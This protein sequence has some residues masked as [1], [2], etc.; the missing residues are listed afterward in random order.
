V[1]ALPY[2]SCAVDVVGSQGRLQ[3]Q[4]IREI[5]Q[6][7]A[8]GDDLNTNS[9]VDHD[10]DVELVE[11]HS[12]EGTETYRDGDVPTERTVERMEA[13]PVVRFAFDVQKVL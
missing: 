1:L 4:H 11:S 8:E 13:W 12:A 7:Y 5:A 6:E 9:V 2:A 10:A 3:Y